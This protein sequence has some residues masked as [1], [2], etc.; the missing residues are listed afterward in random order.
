M[1]M[2]MFSTAT[3][4]GVAPTPAEDFALENKSINLIQVT[5]D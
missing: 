2:K 3:E 1:K 5:L 4:G